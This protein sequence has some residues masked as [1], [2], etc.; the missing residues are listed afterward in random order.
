MRRRARKLKLAGTLKT[1][2]VTVIQRFD[3]AMGLNVHFHS[4]FL[5]GVFA[6]DRR[7]YPQFHPVPAP[8]DEDVASVTERILR[9]VYKTLA[10]QQDAYAAQD[11]VLASLS[12]AS[13]QRR[14]ALGPRR[15]FPL[16][17]L[18]ADSP[19]EAR[20]LGRR[21]AQVE[22]FNL[23]ANTRVPADDRQG[24]E[25]LCR[26]VGRPPLSDDRLE[27]AADGNPTLRL[28]KPWSDGTT[29]LVFT[30]AEFIEKLIPLIPRP[31]A[32][33]VRYSGVLAPA[34]GWREFV[35]PEPDPRA[36]EVASRGDPPPSPTTRVRI[37]WADLL[38]RVFLV[39]ALECPRCHGRM[40]L[41]SA[42]IQTAALE[43][44]LKHMALPS[45]PP[46][47]RS[48]RAPPPPK[49]LRYDKDHIWD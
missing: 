30:P 48:P 33:L 43:R 39:D 8:T 28:K 32:H 6:L 45:S 47:I 36:A 15:G 4:L 9:I 26:Y 13:I 19:V 22:G 18:V 27:Q 23:H 49:A 34:A 35:V 46:L 40:R 3:S 5:D 2:A 17:R 31:R 37:P 41:I 1:G 14:V 7:G 24:L 38:R 42:V 21:C 10:D 12:S 25:N 20:I 44:I 29:H 11:P 16:R